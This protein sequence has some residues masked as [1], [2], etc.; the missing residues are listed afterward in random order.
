MRLRLDAYGLVRLQR[1]GDGA[2]FYWSAFTSQ[3]LLAR[4]VFDLLGNGGVQSL[5][6]CQGA[7]A[8]PELLRKMRATRAAACRWLLDNAK[9]YTLR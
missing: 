9:R 1:P 3:G 7:P 4:A 6:D 8:A 5:I 2:C